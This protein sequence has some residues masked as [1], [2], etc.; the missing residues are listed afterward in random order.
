MRKGPARLFT[1]VIISIL[2]SVILPISG[3]TQSESQKEKAV[4]AVASIEDASNNSNAF[5]TL[6]GNVKDTKKRSGDGGGFNGIIRV[7]LNGT[8]VNNCRE[9]VIQYCNSRL[10]EG[11]VPGNLLMIFRPRPDAS[12]QRFNVTSRCV[13]ESAD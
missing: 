1:F 12:D 8:T 5:C 6:N 7:R 4:S 2:V 3:C 9:Q 11:Y 13:I 10:A